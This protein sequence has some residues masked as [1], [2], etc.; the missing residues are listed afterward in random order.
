MENESIG[1][2]R[3]PHPGNRSEYFRRQCH[4]E[5]LVKEQENG[6][7]AVLGERRRDLRQFRDN[8]AFMNFNLLP[9]KRT[10]ET[11]GDF[12]D[13]KNACNMS[14]LFSKEAAMIYYV[15]ADLVCS[16]QT[17]LSS[18]FRD[19][20]NLPEA[21]D[22]NPVEHGVVFGD[23]MDLYGSDG[24]V[25]ALT[26]EE[27]TAMRRGIQEREKHLNRFNESLNGAKSDLY[28]KSFPLGNSP[29]SS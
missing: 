2:N 1:R 25:A 24:D 26:E 9:T 12:S 7:C 5:S 18:Y 23:Y 16:Q 17:R 14:S 3:R 10:P 20:A 4:L 28:I 21:N 22:I 27:R 19:A 15:H 8:R 29:T 6:V 13:E 11:M